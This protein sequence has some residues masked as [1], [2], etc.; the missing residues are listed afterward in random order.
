MGPPN[1]AMATKHHVEVELESTLDSVD[2]AEEMALE[3]ARGAGF[4][5][6]DQ[7]KIGMA[8]RESMVNAI[9]HGNQYDPAKRAGL[10]LELDGGK[11]VITVTDQG[12]GFDISN[13]PNPLA[14]EN[15]LK[16]SGRGIFLIQSFMDE[17]QVR[18]R[19]P[20]GTELR[21]IKYPAPANGREESL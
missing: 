5:E 8:V 3:F 18:R 6:D 4:D 19:S 17:V 15:L 10:R 9:Y 11:L 14:E 16:Q 1:I 13:V 20:H 2:R 12:Q 21:M 7:M